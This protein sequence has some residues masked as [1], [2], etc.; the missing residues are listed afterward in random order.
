MDA[1]DLRTETTVGERSNDGSSKFV[2]A[3]PC[4]TNKTYETMSS[5]PLGKV[6]TPTSRPC[7]V[8]GPDRIVPPLSAGDAYLKK[9]H[10]EPWP[11]MDNT[12]RQPPEYPHKMPSYIS[13]LGNISP[14]QTFQENMPRIM[15]QPTY[16]SKVSEEASYTLDRNLSKTNKFNGPGEPKYCDVPYPV[17]QISSDQKNTEMCVPNVNNVRNY[18]QMWHPTSVNMRPSRPYGAPELYQYPE[19]ASCTGPRPVP[20][21]RP[22]RTINEES[23]HVYSDPYYHENNIRFKPYPNVKERYPQAR[24]EY[25]GNYSN[26]FH[27]PHPYPPYKYDIQKPLPPHATHS[28]VPSIK[29]VDNRMVDSSMDGYQ[30]PSQGPYASPYRNQVIHPSYGPM[31]GNNL[32]NKIYAYPPES[33]VKPVVS[34]KLPYDS[35]LYTDYDLARNKGF[36][37]SENFYDMRTHMKNQVIIPNY[38]A[39]NM[40]AIHPHAYY[41]KENVTSKNLEYISHLRH[42]DPAMNPNAFSK[43]SSQFSP[44]S[45]AISPSDSNTSNDTGHTQVGSLEDCGYVSQSSTGS[46][47]SADSSINR[48]MP[49]DFHRRYN[50]P[51]PSTVRMSPLTS[52]PEI[53]KKKGIDVRQFLQMWNEGDEENNGNSKQVLNQPTQPEYNNSN[54]PSIQYEIAKNHEQLYVLGLMNVPSE[55]LGKYDH[56]QKV[57]KLPENIKGYNNIELLKHFEEAIESSNLSTLN[58]KQSLPRN[59]HP[60]ITTTKNSLLQALPPRPLSPLDVEAKISQS[61]IHKEVGCNFEIKPCSPEM[62]NVEVATP[63]QNIINERTI[64]KVTNPLVAK[65]PMLNNPKDNENMCKVMNQNDHTL[66]LSENNKIPSCKMINTQCLNNDSTN[67]VKANYS[68]QDLE[69]NAG[70][71]L[72]SLPRLDNDIEL[73]FP[74]VNQQF[75]NANKETVITTADSGV[76][77]SDIYYKIDEPEDDVAHTPKLHVNSDTEKEFSKLSKYRKIKRND[78]VSTEQQFQINSQSIRTDSVII[79]N[80]ENTKSIDYT[81]DNQLQ[82]RAQELELDL[83]VSSNSCLN[84][85]KANKQEG[86][87]EIAIDFSL[88]KL[89]NSTGTGKVFIGPG[90]KAY[91]NNYKVSDSEHFKRAYQE[92]L[93]TNTTNS[94]NSNANDKTTLSISS[95]DVNNRPIVRYEEHATKVNL[96]KESLDHN[97]IGNSSN[98]GNILHAKNKEN[99]VNEKNKIGID[100]SKDVHETET[101]DLHAPLFSNKSKNHTNDS[102]S[103]TRNEQKSFP[104]TLDVSKTENIDRNSHKEIRDTLSESSENSEEESYT[105]TDDESIYFNTISSKDTDISSGGTDKQKIINLNTIDRYSG[106]DTCIVGETEENNQLSNIETSIVSS[107]VKDAQKDINSTVCG[108]T[109]TDKNTEILPMEIGC[110]SLDIEM[111]LKE[112]VNTENVK[113]TTFK[114]LEVCRDKIQNKNECG[115]IDMQNHDEN[116]YNNVDLKKVEVCDDTNIESNT[117]NTLLHVDKSSEEVHLKEVPPLSNFNAVEISL[118][119]NDTISHMDISIDNNKNLSENININLCSG[120]TKISNLID[121]CENKR[122]LISNEHLIEDQENSKNQNHNIDR[123]QFLNSNENIKSDRTFINYNKYISTHKSPI[124]SNDTKETVIKEINLKKELLSPWIQ[125]LVLNIEGVCVSDLILASQNESECC[126]KPEN[127]L[128]EQFRQGAP[129]SLNISPQKSEVINNDEVLLDK[130]NSGNEI[131]LSSKVS[132]IKEV[133]TVV[134]PRPNLIETSTEFDKLNSEIELDSLP[135]VNLIKELETVRSPKPNLIVTSTDLDKINLETQID[136]SEIHLKPLETVISSK[137][138]LIEF[139]EFD[140][141]NS[142]TE[143]SFSKVHPIKELET[144]ISPKS[145]TGFSPRPDLKES[146]SEFDTFNSETELNSPSKLNLI[147]EIENT[148]SPKSKL[149]GT[150][151]EHSWVNTGSSQEDKECNI[152]LLNDENNFDKDEDSEIIENNFIDD[153]NKETIETNFNNDEDEKVLE[154]NFNSDV[155]NAMDS[156]IYEIDNDSVIVSENAEIIQQTENSRHLQVLCNIDCEDP[157]EKSLSEIHTDN[158]IQVYQSIKEQ[159]YVRRNLKRSLSDS[160]LNFY[161]NDIQGNEPQDGLNKNMDSKTKKV[162]KNSKAFLNVFNIQNNRRNSICSMYNEENMSFCIVID[163]N[164][165]ISEENEEEEEKICYNIPEECLRT[166]S[167]DINEGDIESTSEII[168]CPQDDTCEYV[169]PLVLEISDEKTFE[170]SWVDDVACVETVVSDD[171]AEDVVIS[172]PSSPRYIDESDDD[173]TDIFNAP[174]EHTEKVKYIYGDKMCNDDAELVETLYRT[175]QMDVNKTLINREPHASENFD[176]YVPKEV[177]AELNK[178]VNPEVVI[179]EA[180]AEILADRTDISESTE[181]IYPAKD[182]ILSLNEIA[183][184]NERINTVEDVLSETNAKKDPVEDVISKSNE[185]INPFETGSSVLNETIDS[186]MDH[187]SKSS[188]TL[189][190]EPENVTLKNTTKKER[191]LMRRT[192]NDTSDPIDNSSIFSSV[193]EPSPIKTLHYKCSNISNPITQINNVNSCEPSKDAIVRCDKDSMDFIAFSSPEVSST[194]TDEKNSSILLKITNYKGTRVSHLTDVNTNRS[195][196]SCRFTENVNYSGYQSNSTKPRPLIT[197]AAQK[198]IPPA[199]DTVVDDLKVKLALP[200]H[201]LIKFKQLKISRNESNFNTVSKND[202]KKKPKPRFEDVLK[203]IDEI[204]FKMH[205]E[206]SKKPKKPVPKVVIKKNENGSHYASTPIK[207]PFNPDLTGRKW[208]PWVFIEKNIF[209]DKMAVRKKTKAIFNHRK[210]TYVFA[211]KFKKYKSIPSAKFVISQ[212]KLDDSSTGHFKYTIRLKHTY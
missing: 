135:K 160:A 94:T 170:E 210:N 189:V 126:G 133:E 179:S 40:Q 184:S 93:D 198:Y 102:I 161:N 175:P 139:T 138:N 99:I 77:P 131:D 39:T 42:L 188:D 122:E 209:V 111:K 113:N 191:G 147:N 178:T 187:N 54:K 197:K 169:E 114:S 50:Y 105:N 193:I 212:P 52:K 47:R 64:E 85:T 60:P 117:K 65:P 121:E 159:T 75:I 43:L 20:M 51:Y 123:V 33:P 4:N 89:E 13:P 9:G 150:S 207:E 84:D 32:P 97:E 155:D 164:C 24:Y 120:K 204:Q 166:I 78:V 57:S 118:K 6:E 107:K 109:Y 176:S 100:N 119:E 63:A 124:S 55:E 101:I 23:A 173:E 203:S 137:S 30:R 88:N 3:I 44:S 90:D 145:K 205:K 7:A 45:I 10:Y 181:I 49:N 171:I 144:V 182:G 69:S 186:A 211:D 8:I 58:Q 153:E 125:K 28:Q 18:P 66:I 73:N 83:T 195:K 71:C 194:T 21:T 22:H 5:N 156:G 180:N 29:Y 200:Q 80:P 103:E 17:N 91:A 70:V 185:K 201:S 141:S 95:T 76:K 104:N 116:N 165:I 14:R 36:P 158:P 154:N 129:N 68:L 96:L 46:I 67:V 136:S 128:T 140:K 34:N 206:K 82:K 53:N 41:R 26:P 163:N 199:K 79:K 208:Q 142:V 35:K 190:E 38:P 81:T 157:I 130:L 192:K 56:I 108:E 12:Y 143:D 62:L 48:V 25:V 15:V 115:G 196:N 132:L 134:S 16:N 127:I 106:T 92:A 19:Y 146:S 112:N 110:S 37:V 59:F 2:A 86:V 1:K 27:P 162:R 168:L 174:S 152:G 202:I 98:D 183:Q 61:V 87:N 151:T 11:P 72:A 177:V 148:I 149:I 74:E 167:G 172:A 31:I